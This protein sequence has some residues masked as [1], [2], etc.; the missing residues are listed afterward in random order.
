MQALITALLAQL[1]VP[2][3]ASWTYTVSSWGDVQLNLHGSPAYV[4]LCALEGAAYTGWYADGSQHD[5]TVHALGVRITALERRDE[6]VARQAEANGGHVGLRMGPA[7]AV[8]A[9]TRYAVETDASP[10]TYESLG[11][12][13][14]VTFPTAA[15][16]E[17]AAS[18]VREGLAE[19]GGHWSEVVV[20]VAEVTA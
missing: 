20:W 3:D 1:G 16:A 15:E 7:P 18:E 5:V 12:Y 9:A 8:A 2:S 4:C 6:Y 14:G 17:Q 19:A 10:D 11:E 13:Y